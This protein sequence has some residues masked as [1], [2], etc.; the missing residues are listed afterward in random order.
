MPKIRQAIAVLAAVAFCISFNTLRYPVVREMVEAIAPSAE[1]AEPK[2]AEKTTVADKGPDAP[3]PT[4]TPAPKPPPGVVCKDG[5]CTM[6]QPDSPSASLSSSSPQDAVATSPTQA[7]EKPASPAESAKETDATSKPPDQAE[8][9]PKDEATM[10]DSYAAAKPPD[11][12]ELKSKDETAKSDSYAPSGEPAK[13]D[14]SAN[15]DS[16]T[17]PPDGPKE[18]VPGKTAAKLVSAWGM[19]STPSSGEEKTPA[20][21]VTLVPIERPKSRS[22][23]MASA[24]GPQAFDAKPEAEQKSSAK[25]VRH[26]PPVDH[27]SSD[28]TPSLTPD[29]VRTYPVTPAP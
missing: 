15:S 4:D 10:S 5:V 8:S 29:Q 25:S 21:Q 26:L 3:S 23:E 28:E 9:K 22:K 16:S 18:K 14:A 1:A 13:S 27:V 2:P 6:T 7:E 12:A 24:A 17:P 11:Q 19:S 20:A